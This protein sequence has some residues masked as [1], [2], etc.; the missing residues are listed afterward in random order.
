[1][2]FIRPWIAMLACMCLA[3]PAFA[4]G[5]CTGGD[6]KCGP[7]GKVLRCSYTDKD[8]VSTPVACAGPAA[9]GD[10]DS[11]RDRSGGACTPGDKKCGPDGKVLRC[12]YTDK[13]WV[14]TPVRC[15]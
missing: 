5:R 2:K 3:L 1:M 4:Q 15:S 14:S 10:A 7:D 8:W 9:H 13:D 11:H 6:K 12:S